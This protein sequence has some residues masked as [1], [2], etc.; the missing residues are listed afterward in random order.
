MVGPESVN[1]VIS[2]CGGHPFEAECIAVIRKH[3]HVYADVSAL[4]YPTFQLWHSLRLV[5]DYGVFDKLLFGSDFPLT[6]VD[7]SVAGLRAV[8]SVPGIPGLDPLDRDQVEQL[9]HRDA[10]P[11]LGLR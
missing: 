2:S 1:S 9:T 10:L 5:Q 7:A 8:A 6:T 3:Q 11:M 4:H